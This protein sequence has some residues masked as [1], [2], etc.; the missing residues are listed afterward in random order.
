MTDSH[1]GLLWG[2]ASEAI[3]PGPHPLALHMLDVA[4]V[5]LELF[6]E[7]LPAP[8]AADL[9]TL[10]PGQQIDAA[11][12]GFLV[13]C[14]DL[15][16]ATPGF[17]AK[18]PA[19][20]DR[21]VAQGFDF[22]PTAETDHGASTACLLPPLLEAAGASRAGARFATQAVAA[23]HGSYPPCGAKP[24]RARF[25][26]DAW[27]HLRVELFLALRDAL[28]PTPSAFAVHPSDAWILGM[29]GLTVLADWVGSDTRFFAYEPGV[30]P[31]ADYLARARGKA[32][33]ALH[34]LGFR[35]LPAPPSNASTFEGLWGFEPHPMQT[36][37]AEMVEA[38][39][40]PGLI[41]VESQTGGGK[42]EAAIYAAERMIAKFGLGG[43]YF[44]LPSQA[45]SNQMFSRVRTYLE[46]RA[47]RAGGER[48]QLQLLHGGRD[49]DVA[50]EG[51]I[52]P[53]G[54]DATDPR[55]A[56]ID[57]T[58][59]TQA[60]V[61]AE[62]W[63]LGKKRG[64][65]APFAVG[66]VDQALLSAL[67]TRHFFLRMFGL[68]RKVLVIDEVHAYDAFM[69]RILDRLLAWLRTLGSGVV[70][71][72][73]TLP[74]S[75]KRDL[76]AAWHGEHEP[77]PGGRSWPAYPRVMSSDGEVRARAVERSPDARRI[78]ALAWRQPSASPEDKARETA[79][80]LVE[81][82][83]D[84]GTAAWIAN[85]VREAQAA[86]A[87]LA[88]AGLKADERLLFHARFPAEERRAREQ[89]VLAR[90]DKKASR[91]QRLV[92]VAT[93][94]IEQSLDIDVD[95]MVTDLAPI[96]LLIQRAGRLH[97]H[98]E[99][100]PA[101]P[102]R[103]ARPTLWILGRLAGAEA[104]A[105]GPSGFV[106]DPHVL[107]R[108]EHVLQGRSAWTLPDETDA[109]LDAVYPADLAQLAT[110][111][112]HAT[113]ALAVAWSR[114][115]HALAHDLDIA[116]TKGG[117]HLVPAPCTLDS[118]GSFIETIGLALDDA[119]DAPHKHADVLAKTR[120]IGMT[121]TVVCLYRADGRVVLSPRDA[122]PVPFEGDARDKTPLPRPVVRRLLE[123]AVTLQHRAI[124]RAA[125]QEDVP[126]AWRYTAALR[127]LRP[128]VFGPDLRASLG[129]IALRLDPDLGLVLGDSNPTLEDL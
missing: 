99:R 40:Q 56:G 15:G 117:Q 124:V 68:A 60:S 125:I 63:F 82:L 47:V 17:Q 96:D 58:S 84:G 110:P 38:L 128:L 54:M 3:V 107:L 34:A 109:L 87:A 92:V 75:R 81:A 53:Q 43:F 49:L 101:R 78:L 25:G 23:H 102:A 91:P 74:A 108:T 2:K 52:A 65:L 90:L 6:D 98:A 126:P 42:T 94:V 57:G 79:R 29:S 7:L 122:T 70:L 113:P 24:S 71:L 85:T 14:H 73:A 77:P 11:T 50:F 121:V 114:S 120:D 33:S 61:V 10:A 118:E 22:P 19:L 41:I 123:R 111:P 45:T 4:A 48:V 88:E 64:L 67:G 72:S 51:S 9:L 35:P 28:A 116:R 37:V 105:F 39:A 30:A 18:V 100:D 13:A 59:R 44:A 36:T 62:A 27:S 115:A 103:L 83:S 80:A 31:S 95:L 46:G 16:K 89:S 20:R 55:L 129:G 93:Q 32:R 69:S 112:D 12:L 76:F 21:L 106:Y 5:A 127:H 8:L 97:R 66:T 119:E 104:D 86:Y 26:K 1:L